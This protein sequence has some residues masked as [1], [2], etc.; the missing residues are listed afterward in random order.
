MCGGTPGRSTLGGAIPRSSRQCPREL[1]S[2]SR[3]SP[4]PGR[5]K[6]PFHRVHEG[7]FFLSVVH[8]HTHWKQHLT[9]APS[10]RCVSAHSLTPVESPAHTNHRPGWQVVGWP[11]GAGRTC[12][13][14]V[15]QRGRP[16]YPW[17]S[18]PGHIP[19]APCPPDPS[20][21]CKRSPMSPKVLR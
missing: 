3:P 20:P 13:T 14:L 4:T 6:W 19:T 18:G 17:T 8:T 1:L 10:L 11:V 21:K 9:H 15:V 16:M 7:H 5:P 2:S 12:R